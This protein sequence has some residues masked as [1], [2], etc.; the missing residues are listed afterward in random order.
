MHKLLFFLILIFI[1]FSCFMDQEKEILKTVLPNNTWKHY[2]LEIFR[3]K[4]IGKVTFAEN[5]F[6]EISPLG[7]EKTGTYI[8]MDDYL[9]M[10]YDGSGDFAGS[11]I[12]SELCDCFF[13]DSDIDRKFIRINYLNRNI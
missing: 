13:I 9:I 7:I 4:Y 8:Y 11:V 1:L 12:D 6:V 2:K 3:Q 10:E 5:T